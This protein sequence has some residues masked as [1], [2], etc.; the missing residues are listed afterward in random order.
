[1]RLAELL[2]GFSAVADLGMGLPIGEAARTAIVAVNLA[3][4][5]GCPEPEVSDV[6]FA[7]LLQHIGCTAYAHEATELFADEFSIKRAG[8]ATDFTRQSEIIL[9]YLP[10]IT[11][12]SPAGERFRTIRSAL[13][14]S[15]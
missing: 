15:R 13:L 5:A 8:L 9:S 7:A 2:V 3:R 11:R 1:M 14:H 12:E 4:G 10:R 6:F